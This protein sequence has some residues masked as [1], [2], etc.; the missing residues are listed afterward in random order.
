MTIDT[1]AL[2]ERIRDEI[3]G[4]PI[5]SGYYQTVVGVDEA[6][7]IAAAILPDII[8]EV[9]AAKAEAWEKGWEAAIDQAPG[10]VWF[11][12]WHY[13]TNPYRATEHETGDQ[14]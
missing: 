11:D 7:D 9:Q 13:Q 1:T 14:A 6:S 10:D 12:E 5:G 8:A 3:A 2:K 4:H